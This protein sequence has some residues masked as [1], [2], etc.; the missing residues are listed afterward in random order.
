MRPERRFE[1]YH[2]TGL[3][4]RIAKSPM[5]ENVTLSIA[6]ASAQ[7]A[8]YE[9]RWVSCEVCLSALWIAVDADLNTAAALI[10]ADPVFQ[11]MENVFCS[12][13]TRA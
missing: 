3:A 12:L 7:R 5:F 9:A 6:W 8:T 10:D 4:Q 13:V 11:I 2:D 1:Y